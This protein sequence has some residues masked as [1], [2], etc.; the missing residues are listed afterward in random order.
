ML[1]IIRD[2]RGSAAEIALRLAWNLGLT[3]DEMYNLKWS[4]I[5]FT[6]KI[7]F[8]SNREV[9]MEDE[10]VRCLEARSRSIRGRESE[11]VMA[12]DR[13]HTR[14]A[15]Q[16]ISR[17]ARIALE[18]GGL[19]GFTLLD[20]RQD[21]II[22]M[23][24]THDWTYAARITG[25]SVTTLY[26]NYSEYF[27]NDV[28][29]SGK[30]PQDEDVE[31]KLWRIIREEGTS[32]AGLALW[33][34]WKLEMTIQEIAT[35][36]WFQVDFVK[37]NIKVPGRNVKMGSEFWTKLNSVKATRDPDSSPYV[38]LTPRA[39]KGFDAPRL[40]RVLR[41]VLIRGG[42]DMTLKDILAKERRKDS[43]YPIVELVAKKGSA[44][45]NEIMQEVSLSKPQVCRRIERLVERGELVRV[46]QKLYL[47]G[48]VVAPEE[49][50]EVICAYLEKWNSAVRSDLANLLHVSGNQCGVI[51]KALVE[52]GK[53]KRKGRVYSLPDKGT[54][55]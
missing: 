4:D 9:K 33:M 13:N 54:N 15:P 51:L 37:G 20:L 2:N 55:M 23:L 31:F 35:L 46:G 16:S 3:R 48:T 25:T 17:V 19:E 29:K 28:K 18:Q 1:Q 5:S 49:Q 38:L 10:D 45:R 11:Y 14:M 27:A 50:Y 6:E 8:L 39:Q 44:T 47:P 40:S 52:E 22:R 26:A 42:V 53:L 43:D 24:K 36:T 30:E 32:P 41:D 21:Y 34:A 12:S 7:I